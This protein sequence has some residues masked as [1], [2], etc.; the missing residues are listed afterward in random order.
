MAGPTIPV[1][2]ALRFPDTGPGPY[3]RSPA[4]AWSAWGKVSGHLRTGQ[5]HSPLPRLFF[6]LFLPSLLPSFPGAGGCCL[7]HTCF[8]AQQAE[9]RAPKCP[10]PNQPAARAPR[11]SPR[12]LSFPGGLRSGISPPPQPRLLP[13]VLRS[14]YARDSWG[15]GWRV[16]GR[17]RRGQRSRAEGIGG[18]GRAEEERARELRSKGGRRTSPHA[19]LLQRLAGGRLG[20]LARSPCPGGKSHRPGSAG[21]G[22]PCGSWAGDAGGR[23]GTGGGLAR[24]GVL[25][26]P[27]SRR[28][29]GSSAPASSLGGRGGGTCGA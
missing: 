24:E 9:R 2:V 22:G 4:E 6:L 7:L 10:L 12:T 8:Q 21:G 11:Q 26:P 25:A 3:A 5:F 20:S 18:E 17:E 27:R 23:L 16:Q 15:R 29:G 13:L 19:C 28:P 14:Q 1:S